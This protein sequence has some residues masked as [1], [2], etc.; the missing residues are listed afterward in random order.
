MGKRTTSAPQTAVAAIEALAA[1][2]PDMP[3]GFPKL[4]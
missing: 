4:L 2:H 3:P 1:A